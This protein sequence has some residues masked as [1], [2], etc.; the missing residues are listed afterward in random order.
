MIGKI[1]EL[2]PAPALCQR[3]MTRSYPD[4]DAIER[5][6]KLTAATSTGSNRRVRRQRACDEFVVRRAGELRGIRLASRARK[7]LNCP[8]Y[9]PRIPNR[10]VFTRG[11]TTAA[12][13]STQAPIKFQYVARR[14]FTC[15]I[16]RPPEMEEVW[17]R[18]VWEMGVDGACGSVPLLVPGTKLAEPVVDRPGD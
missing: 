3:S 13:H 9:A 10:S 5:V 14:R 4:P 16:A 7:R 17:K 8:L 2:P 11:S 1:S 6:W 18:H 12:S 15:E